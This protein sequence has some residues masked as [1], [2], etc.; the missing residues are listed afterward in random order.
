VR[1]LE[2]FR[3]LFETLTTAKGAIKVF[4]QVADH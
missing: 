1:G 3:Q 2:S 4:C